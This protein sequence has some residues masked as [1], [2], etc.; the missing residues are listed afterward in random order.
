MCLAHKSLIISLMRMS[1][2]VE[3]SLKPK[4]SEL[5]FPRRPSTNGITEEETVDSICPSPV[6]QHMSTTKMARCIRPMTRYL[7]LRLGR[8]KLFKRDTTVLAYIFCVDKKKFL[9]RLKFVR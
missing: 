6:G 7:M 8:P 1:L 3:F 5:L 2:R 9:A 4:V